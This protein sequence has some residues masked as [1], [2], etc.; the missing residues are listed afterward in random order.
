M[1][2]SALNDTT[3]STTPPAAAIERPE[4]ESSGNTLEEDYPGTPQ[5]SSSEAGRR[6]SRSTDRDPPS[7]EI[8]MTDALDCNENTGTLPQ[9]SP[10]QHPM[11]PSNIK[12]FDLEGDIHLSVGIATRVVSSTALRLASPKWQNLDLQTIENGGREVCVAE[13]D[14]PEQIKHD[15]TALDLILS[16]VHLRFV[17]LPE[18]ITFEHLFHLAILCSEEKYDCAHLVRPFM[19][20]WAKKWIPFVRVQGHEE[21]LLIS[22]VFG[23]KYVFEDLTERLAVITKL[24]EPAQP[25]ALDRLRA[26]PGTNMLLLYLIGKFSYTWINHS[27]QC[28][29]L[30]HVL[31][32][33][34][35]NIYRVRLELISELLGFCRSIIEVYQHQYGCLRCRGERNGEKVSDREQ[36]DCTALALGC[37][38]RNFHTLDLWPQIPDALSILESY[39]QL[40]NKVVSMDISTWPEHTLCD[41]KYQIKFNVQDIQ[42]P[43]NFRDDIMEEHFVK[44]P[45]STDV[46][47]EPNEMGF[48][49]MDFER[50]AGHLTS[51]DEFDEAYEPP[52]ADDEDYFEPM[53]EYEDLEIIFEPGSL[54]EVNEDS[55]A[56]DQV[57]VI[58]L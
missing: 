31:F 25:N 40:A 6:Q 18:E 55:V 5:S 42:Y 54:D 14:V 20:K 58:E 51:D 17:E 24:G 34:T 4:S 39:E 30:T 44:N 8:N 21:W 45:A 32:T 2:R 52:D 28:D 12:H 48:L 19:P 37:L 11:S 13:L 46:S 15:M 26:H 35:N 56:G 50:M 3:F 38:M 22:W 9:L 49:P 27:Y 36:D 41:P 23:Y 57:E 43:S 7:N 1:P 29:V 53:E 33:F 47:P 16:I 10:T